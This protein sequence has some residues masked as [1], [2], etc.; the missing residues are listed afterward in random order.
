MS[1][2]HK[3]GM[4]LLLTLAFVLLVSCHTTVGQ[5]YGVARR[6]TVVSG[7]R[8]TVVAH[9]TTVVHTASLP[10]GYY[11]CLPVGY[12][13]VQ[14][15]GVRYYVVGGVYYQPRFYSGRTV[16]VRVHI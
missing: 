9:S 11:C 13:A 4:V 14:V 8:G 10:V 7:N 2:L 6:T 12:R 1:N 16:Y 15:S 3:N 5:V